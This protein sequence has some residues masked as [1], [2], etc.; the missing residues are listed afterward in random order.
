MLIA[1]HQQLYEL[2]NKARLIKGVKSLESS[3]ALESRVATLE[4]IPDN[5]SNESLFSDEKPKANNRKNP[6]LERKG[7]SNKQT[8]TNIDD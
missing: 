7:S 8:N 6:A 5:S 2:W 1:Q 3:R 4:A